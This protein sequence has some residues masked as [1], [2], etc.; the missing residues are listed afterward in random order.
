MQQ[1]YDQPT[2]SRLRKELERKREEIL[3]WRNQA[4]TS[5]E[6]LGQRESEPEEQA[7]AETRAQ[8]LHSQDEHTR[9]EIWEIDAAITRM[10]LGTFG[11]CTGCG[12]R[13]D[14]S[15]IEAVPW[16][17]YCMRCM[18]QSIHH[19]SQR[20]Q[21]DTDQT[22]ESSLPSTPPPPLPK[23]FQG[24]EEEQ[25]RNALLE[26]LAQDDRLALADLAPRLE[27]GVLVL[28]G[29]VPS[30]NDRQLLLQV[31]HDTL[32]F[33]DL[34]DRLRVEP[35]LF[36]RD[37]GQP[38]APEN[39]PRTEEQELLEGQSADTDIQQAR[40]EGGSIIPPDRFQDPREQ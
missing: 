3:T 39:T 5:R 27:Q 35:L 10:D 22:L 28:E 16:T 36:Q 14:T 31:L 2:M 38:A 25:F 40:E 1:Q 32:G 18:D 11:M 15:R 8:K 20:A 6:Q 37:A 4:A 9:Q 33:T 30:E 21:E 17:R 24:M 7:Q 29:A 23:D 26:R 34:Q 12:E 19:S 13:I